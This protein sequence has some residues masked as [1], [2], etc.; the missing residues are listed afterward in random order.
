MNSTK[1]SIV[2]NNGSQAAGSK[3]M[4]TKWE[5]FCLLMWKNFL[6]Q[7]RHKIQ[8]L[9]EI[10]IPALFSMLVV[11]IRSLVDPDVYDEATIYKPLGLS[12]M[13]ELTKIPKFQLKFFK[14]INDRFKKQGL[15]NINFEMVYSP[16]NPVLENFVQRVRKNI[17]DFPLIGDETVKGLDNATAL[18]SYMV[19]KNPLVGL[20]M[21]DAY[22]NITQMPTVLKYAIRLPGEL[23][24]TFGPMWANW[25]TDFLFPFIQQ[26]GARNKEYDDGGV[27]PGYYRESF[28]TLQNAVFKTFANITAGDANT[29]LPENFIR[30]FPYPPFTGDPLLQAMERMLSIF[31]LLSFVYPCIN[32]VK[33]ITIE[34]EKQLKESM[35]IMGLPN[36]LHWS[37]WFVKCFIYLFFATL[38]MLVLMKAHWYSNMNVTVFTHSGFF[39]LWFYLMVYGVATIMFCF[40]LSVFF[41]KANTA[42]AVA[43]LLWFVTYAPFSL[44]IQRY[45]SVTFGQKIAASFFSN[46]AM[47]FGFLLILRHEGNTEG[48]QWSNLFE[49][50]NIEDDYTVGHTVVMMLVSSVIYFVL[51]LYVEKVLPGEFGVAEP[52]YFPFTRTFWCGEPGFQGIEDIN[53]PVL[54]GE[55][56]VDVETEPIGKHAGI[57]TK[58]LRK[59]YRNKKTAVKGLTL[60]MFDDEITVLLGH[61]GAG[62]T[63]TMAMLTGMIPPT[64]GNAI[65][66]GFDIRK[67]LNAVR[68]SLGICFQHNVLFDELTVAEH[69]EFFARLKGLRKHEIKDEI[70][71]YVELLQLQDKINA[72]AHTL[73]GG[74]QRKLSIGI[75]LC[76]N[77]KV[78]LCD[79]PTSGVD[80]SARRALWDLLLAEKKGRT[81]LL[82]THFMDEADILG[83][84]IAIMNEGA[85]KAVGSPFYLKKRYGTGYRLVI[86]KNKACET[87]KVTQLLQKYVTDIEVKTD[88]G[89]ELSYQL[90][91]KD[92]AIFKDMLKDLEENSEELKLNSYG[93]SMA[94]LEEVFMS[95]GTDEQKN[96]T[97]E[98]GNGHIPNGHATVV[99]IEKKLVPEVDL[100]TG[101]KLLLYQIQGLFA[102]KI[103]H[104][105]RH[106]VLM[107]LQ[108]LIPVTFLI[109]CIVIVR[110]WGG[111][112]DLPAL[113]LVPE[114]Y[115][116]T[117]TLLEQNSSWSYDDFSNSIILYYQKLIQRNPSQQEFIKAGQDMN[118]YYLKI[119]REKIAR[120]NKRYMF[121]ASINKSHITAWFN[122]QPY[123]TAPIS[124]GLVHNATLMALCE[125]DTC[126]ID[127]TNKPLPYRLETRFDM[128]QAGNN[129]GFQLA[130][131]VGFAM[132]F[133]AAFYVI[134]Y[135]KERISRSK[136]LQFVSG[137]NIAS[138][139]ITG[140]LWDYF[141][142][143]C[144]AVISLLTIF[145][146]QETGWSTVP[147]MGRCL[148]VLMCFIWAVLPFTY[149]ASLLFTAPATGFTR[150]SIIYIFS[151]VAVFTVVFTMSFEGFKLKDT[152]DLFTNIFLI[153]P[154]F[155][156]SDSLSN[157]NILN[158][159]ISVCDKRCSL[160]PNCK[161]EELCKAHPLFARCCE[162]NFFKWDDPGI[163]KNLFYMILT[164][165]TTFTILL[166]H[167]YRIFEMI[168][169]KGVHLY[170]GPPIPE[171]E[172]D[173]LDQDVKDEK[174]R[175]NAME[176]EQI[177][178]TNLVLKNMTKFYNRLLAVNQTCVGV[179]ENECFGLL[180]INGAGKSSTFKMLCGDEK[181]SYGEAYVQGASLKTNMKE[182]YKRIGYCP[183]FDA[184]ID[185]LTGRET[186]RIFSL[187]RGVPKNRID[188]ITL[189]LANELNYT[190]HLDKKVREYSGGNKRKLSTSIALLGRPSVI[191]LDEPT[192]GMDPLAKRNFWNA[193]CKIRDQGKTIVLTTHSIE[194]AEALCTRLC[195]MVNG[196]FKCL[197]SSQ[198]LKSKF[199]QGYVLTVKVGRKRQSSPDRASSS[200]N[201]NTENS[202]LVYDLIELNAIKEFVKTKF[203]LSILKEEY[204]GLLTYHIPLAALK[205]YELFGILEEAKSDASLNIEDYSIGQTS[206]EQVF[207]S[208][209]KYQRED[210]LVK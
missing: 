209:T 136:L 122:N 6:L 119:S 151:G 43:G 159:V 58:G 23:R 168:F 137:V 153:F 191:L 210:N 125:N 204:Q 10:F 113:N 48:L 103:L 187:F 18:E 16:K 166:M 201:N 202:T 177:V 181:I 208:F 7:W 26:G 12:S 90:Y 144:T 102:K 70:Q 97:A 63:T 22:Q 143:F 27:P 64:A 126:G 131:N 17:F 45:D 29:T 94:T 5:K 52:W 108:N 111:N 197:G 71:H 139:W 42:A 193:I 89:S 11:M 184:T 76:A 91:T 104:T 118:A 199:S 183:Q 36:W 32:M 79:E 93:I 148:L 196:E 59:V 92:S 68:N 138:Y 15:D 83:D 206:M 85:L 74:M 107:F 180:G 1:Y 21:D 19:S 154:H 124:L 24:T 65:V 54:N 200:I 47:G 55:D 205:W 128:M 81:I 8:T 75:A 4:T 38:V 132:S 194:E 82:S 167:E 189:T 87:P 141:T 62:K 44:T 188:E 133:V 140:F 33:F 190:R 149:L 147:E 162:R 127:I 145:V 173:I 57:E 72:Q 20:E 185:E 99:D 40:L 169:Y 135:I 80:P 2:N 106:F 86:A 46:A 161:M 130:F 98:N 207:L 155:A 117:V 95:I 179:A 50:V 192:T 164:G 66:N 178:S 34:K 9:L 60:K 84:R 116:P 101:S 73:S 109:I 13:R 115:D 28:L 134:F 14:E 120:V 105:R 170:K 152:A 56:E 203:P 30:R 51:A 77:S 49:Q 3:N 174:N 69:I 53:S 25:R 61:N 150:L 160:L 186:L 88:I 172:D 158:T 142:F 198:H 78:V 41:S 123:H 110:S 96:G 37:A 39:V 171:T 67:N 157:L 182:V 156:L 100:V 165:I 175:I 112:K 146:F 163:G 35:K 121:G 195:I 129:L 31:I 176:P 114:K